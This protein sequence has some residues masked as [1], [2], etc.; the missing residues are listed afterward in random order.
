ML[1]RNNQILFRVNDEEHDLLR[2]NAKKCGLSIAA[3]LRF[4]IQGYVTKGTAAGGLS[5]YDPPTAGDRKQYE[6]DRGKG[7]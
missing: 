4:L 3:Y 1:K 6:S 7:E 5:R 2:R